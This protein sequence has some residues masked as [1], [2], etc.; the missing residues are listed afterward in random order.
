MRA[1]LPCQPLR[2]AVLAVMTTDGVEKT[3]LDRLV[4]AL[5]CHIWPEMQRHR[6]DAGTSNGTKDSLH[7]KAGAPTGSA[8]AGAGPAGKP[9]AGSLLS[10]VDR[11]DTWAAPAAVPNGTSSSASGD[12]SGTRVAR[13]SAALNSGADAISVLAPRTNP[14]STSSQPSN[15]A[16]QPAPAGPA[17]A[18]ANLLSLAGLSAPLGGATLNLADLGSIADD[19]MPPDADADG[20]ED[21]QRMF[22][23]LQ[24]VRAQAGQLP[25]A[26]RREMAASAI[27]QLL[28]TPGFMD[29]DGENDEDPY[30]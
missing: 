16:A 11:S 27:M 17:P 12:K 23:T 4:E 7:S 30:A 8:A 25:D 1:L 3:G 10:G 2:D 14:A 9:V 13:S 21:L 18:G 19:H 6:P 24:R 28:S 26:Q 22:D 29:E 5:S 15:A 20:D